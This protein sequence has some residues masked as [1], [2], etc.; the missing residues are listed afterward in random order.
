MQ[1][2]IGAAPPLSKF[3]ARATE[4]ANAVVPR[5]ETVDD[6]FDDLV[7]SPRANRV[8]S[9]RPQIEGKAKTQTE[10]V[11]ILDILTGQVSARDTF[12]T[13]RT[14][15]DVRGVNVLKLTAEPEEV[16]QAK[17]FLGTVKGLL[18]REAEMLVL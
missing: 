2:S 17:I 11:D 1:E 8:A 13:R 12:R 9:F 6:L 16:E 10:E 14:G 18:E 15:V 3:M 7:G 4:K 5:R